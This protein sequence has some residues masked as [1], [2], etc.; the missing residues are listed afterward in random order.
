MQT[1]KR[2]TSTS[3]TQRT[4]AWLKARGIPSTIVEHWNPHVKIRQD[5]FGMFDILALRG[6][7]TIGIQCCTMATRAAHENKMRHA[8]HFEAWCRTGPS[9]ST[10]LAWLVAWRKVGPRGKRKLWECDIVDVGPDYRLGVDMPLPHDAMITA[11]P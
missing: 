3:P 6:D 10:R 1:K 7:Q 2:R 4:R 9:R 11:K 5:L 8:P